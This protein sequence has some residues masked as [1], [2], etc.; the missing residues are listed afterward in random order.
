[1]KTACQDPTVVIVLNCIKFQ[2][3]HENSFLK[4][5]KVETTGDFVG[6]PYV[7]NF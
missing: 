2:N 3:D 6:Q 7:L 5:N 1:M 4:I